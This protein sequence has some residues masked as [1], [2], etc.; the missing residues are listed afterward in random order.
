ML[1]SVVDDPEGAFEGLRALLFDACASLLHARDVDD[2]ATRLEALDGRRFAPLL[3]H[4]EVSNWILFARANAPDGLSPDP[5]VRALHASLSAA[6]AS[7]DWLH[8]HWVRPRMK[9]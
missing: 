7:V 4:Y 8:H 2:A 6:P 9:G 1:Q 3:H 5:R